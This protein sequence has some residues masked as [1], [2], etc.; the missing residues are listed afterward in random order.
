MGYVTKGTVP[1]IPKHN[2]FV[3]HASW[4]VL[5]I[6]TYVTAVASGQAT[7]PSEKAQRKLHAMVVKACQ[8]DDIRRLMDM[9]DLIAGKQSG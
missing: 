7:T 6:R 3:G 9:G 4:A 8:A 5:L 2:L 1:V